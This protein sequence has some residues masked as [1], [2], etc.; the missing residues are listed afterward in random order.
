MPEND[1]WTP[2]VELVDSV[3]RANIYIDPKIHRLSALQKLTLLQQAGIDIREIGMAV[4]DVTV[5]EK[6][7]DVAIGWLV[8]ILPTFGFGPIIR[9]ILDRQLP[10]RL[11]GF[12]ARLLYGS[13]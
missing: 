9:A 13:E 10:E 1:I 12:L 7:T 5:T 4:F 3:K 11:R 2:T 8:D 6:S